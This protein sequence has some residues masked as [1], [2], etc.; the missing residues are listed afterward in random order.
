MLTYAVFSNRGRGWSLGAQFLKSPTDPANLC[1]VPR[2]KFL[3]KF[4]QVSTGINKNWH[5][6]SRKSIDCYLLK[7]TGNS[8]GIN[9][10]IFKSIWTTYEWKSTCWIQ[11]VTPMESKG[12]CGQK[13]HPVN[14]TGTCWGHQQ[15]TSM[16]STDYTEASFTWTITVW[17][18]VPEASD[19]WVFHSWLW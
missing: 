4:W 10:Y 17:S 6:H 15:V 8:S 19:K 5:S 3:L 7:S 9:R 12:T 2:R 13:R 18:L 16:E 14:L 1:P 11:Q